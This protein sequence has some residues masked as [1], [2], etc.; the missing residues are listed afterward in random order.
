M[1]ET[2]LGICEKLS[3]LIKYHENLCDQINAHEAF[4]MW[5][6]DEKIQRTRNVEKQIEYL[7]DVE[8]GE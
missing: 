2:N 6:L 1:Q 4:D 3:F 8:E 5:D 7:L